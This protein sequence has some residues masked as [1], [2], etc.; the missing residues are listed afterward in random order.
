LLSEMELK[1]PHKNSW[2][3]TW[4]EDTKE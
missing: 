1:E 4:E 3:L 2:D